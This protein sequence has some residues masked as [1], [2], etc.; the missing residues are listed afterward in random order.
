MSIPSGDPLYVKK[1]QYPCQGERPVK[2]HVNYH[3]L[4]YREVALV[5]P[6]RSGRSSVIVVW[7]L[8]AGN[9]Q[10]TSF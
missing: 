3:N 5:G 7:K 1:T 8:G 9:N 4:Q 6:Y 2:Q 10:T